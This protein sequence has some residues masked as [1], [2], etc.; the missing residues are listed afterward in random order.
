MT[1]SEDPLRIGLVALFVTSLVVAQLTASKLL[2]FS[3]PVSLPVIAFARDRE[4]AGRPT[5]W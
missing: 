4:Q 1:S 3:L 5:P 2:A